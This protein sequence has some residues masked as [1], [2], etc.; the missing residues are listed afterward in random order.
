M[1]EMPEELDRLKNPP[2]QLF[3]SGDLELLKR[4]KVAIV[5]SR[6]CYTHTQATIFS[7][8]S[9]LSRAGVVVVSGAALGVDTIAHKGAFPNTIAV[10]PNSLEI[11][12]PK[13]N[14]ALI[15]QLHSSSLVLSEYNV[16]TKA[17]K[18]NFIARNRVVVGLCDAVVI[19]QA[20]LNSGTMH[21]AKFAI[22]SNI[23]LYVLG[24]RLGESEG[25]DKLL[26]DGD[27]KLINSID[28]FVKLF[29]DVTKESEEFKIE[30]EL[31][32]FCK[33]SPTFDE[34]LQKFGDKV[35]EYE[36]D[37][38]ITILNGLVVNS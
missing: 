37:G 25:S 19:A 35:Y 3:S 18:Q 17:F 1:L 10:L 14:R 6:K 4:K 8:S 32:E 7:L 11:I 5:G 33:K 21:S 12:Y 2:K 26:V 20:D 28:E 23:P 38:K 22:E 13:T 27:A 36:L 29:S 15:E 31:L 9:A 16:G 30:D 24:H 34:T